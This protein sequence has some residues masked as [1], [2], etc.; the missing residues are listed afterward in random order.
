MADGRRGPRQPDRRRPRRAP[1]ERRAAGRAR[2]ALST[3]RIVDAAVAILDE[4]GPDA[5]TFRRLAGELGVG[6]ASLYWHVD[7]KEDLLMLCFEHVLEADRAPIEPGPGA[8]DWK[9]DIREQLLG[10]FDL[11]ER[12]PWIAAI[13]PGV[14]ADGFSVAV[15]V[16]GLTGERIRS[17]GFDDVRTFYLASALFGSL[18]SI[19]MQTMRLAY[20]PPGRR[21]DVLAEFADALGRQEDQYPGVARLARVM[22]THSDRDQFVAAVDVILAG[23]EAEAA[24]L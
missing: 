18:T 1:S 6:V 21:E 16:L 4:G 10:Y 8:G 14:T 9:R 19:M 20:G 24:K 23:I 17:L 13:A 11:S 2:V 7:D 12:H 22:A 5:L 3:E 15:R